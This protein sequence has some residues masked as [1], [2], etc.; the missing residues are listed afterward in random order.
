MIKSEANNYW[1]HI[2]CQIQYLIS[3][4][5]LN[6]NEKEITMKCISIPVS[7]T[8]KWRL[9]SH[10]SRPS[11]WGTNILVFRSNAPGSVAAV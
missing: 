11:I 1:F 8:G 7:Q 2:M 5:T 9:V 6:N 3:D 10:R 4:I